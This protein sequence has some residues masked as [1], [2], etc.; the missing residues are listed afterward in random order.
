MTEQDIPCGSADIDSEKY[1]KSI[2][3][4]SSNYDLNSDSLSLS[5]G[6]YQ[7]NDDVKLKQDDG[8]DFWLG[9][10]QPENDHQLNDT[11]D[12]FT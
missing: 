3:D 5:G 9:E 2:D 6:P 8:P 7:R 11:C 12:L 1:S 10:S 4:S